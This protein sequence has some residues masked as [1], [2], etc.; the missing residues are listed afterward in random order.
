MNGVIGMTDLL[1][2][3]DLPAQQ[4]EIAETIRV[5]AGT[6]LAIINDILDFSKIEAGKMAMEVVRFRFGQNGRKHVGHSSR[7]RIRQ[8]D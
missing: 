8:G 4:R 3:S 7:E 1:L 6:L 2:D 5:S